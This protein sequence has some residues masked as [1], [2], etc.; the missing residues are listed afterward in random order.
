MRQQSCDPV[1]EYFATDE[2]DLWMMFGL[3]GEVL[4][5]T[6]SDLKPNRPV[7]GAEQSTGIELPRHRDR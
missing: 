7:L 4:T 6:E 2:A 1:F 5:P 3:K